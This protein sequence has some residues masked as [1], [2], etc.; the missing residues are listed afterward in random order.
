MSLF[1]CPVVMSATFFFSR[2]D[3]AMLL[4]NVNSLE[5]NLYVDDERFLPR[6]VELIRYSLTVGITYRK[7]Y[8]N[9]CS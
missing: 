6:L 9:Q 2:D 4:S 3:N 5:A 7:K 1:F 8:L